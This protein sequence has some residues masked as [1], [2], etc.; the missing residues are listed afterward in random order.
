MSQL[1]SAKVGP[2]PRP[3]VWRGRDGGQPTGCSALGQVAFP[4]R[5]LLQTR[6]PAS[7]LPRGEAKQ[8]PLRFSLFPRGISVWTR[9]QRRAN[10]PAHA[11]SP[12]AET[13]RSRGSRRE[14][15]E[16]EHT[17]LSRK[18][19]SLTSSGGALELWLP[20]HWTRASASCTTGSEPLTV[21]S[22]H[23]PPCRKAS[24]ETTRVTE[25]WWCPFLGL[26]PSLAAGEES[27]A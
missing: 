11:P 1:I 9:R 22:P 19:H 24:L 27:Y 4:S 21:R 20:P 8:K 6:H 13:L 25:S 14:V 18:E 12:S 23:F 2:G 26:P 15:G 10:S 5:F 17:S 3:P 7:C 16:V